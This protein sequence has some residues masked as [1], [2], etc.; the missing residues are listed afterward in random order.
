MG[1]QRQYLAS[2]GF[3]EY[4][5]QDES[6][7]VTINGV[8]GKMISK[9]TDPTGTHDGLPTYSNTSDIYFKKGDDGLASQAKVYKDRK[10]V[11][12]FDW[13]HEHKNRNGRVFPKGTVHVQMYRVNSDGSL[14]RLSDNARS[15]NN[16]EMK[17]YGPILKYFNPN[18]KFR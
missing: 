10:T 15:M 14:T 17:K 5:Y 6:E 13:N 18:V 2:G 8:T 16:H 1:N 4:L 9:I 7:R 12:D 11:L 3:S